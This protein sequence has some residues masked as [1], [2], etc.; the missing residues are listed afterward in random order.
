[1]TEIRQLA[2]YYML[3]LFGGAKSTK[4]WTTLSHNGVV[5]QPPYKQHNIP[6]IYDGKSIM[7]P[8][9]AEEY[10]TLFTRYV[11]TEYYK[12]KVFKKNFFKSWKP[13][14]KGLG[15]DKLELCDFS[16]IIKHLDREKEK[17]ANMSKADKESLK[18][19]TDKNEEKYK[20][21]IV[22]GKEQPVGNFRLEPAGIFIG[23]GC[24]PKLGTIKKRVNSKDITINIGK[25]N[26][27]P[28]PNGEKYGKI[29]HN[30]KAEWLASWPDV[31]SGKTKYVWLGQ[32]SEFKAQSDQDKFDKARKLGKHIEKIRKENT[33]NIINGTLTVKQLSTALYFIDNLALRVGNE[34]GSDQAD[35]VGVT[36]LR[37]EHIMLKGNNIIKLDFLGKDSI[38]YVNQVTVSEKVYEN[39]EKF[40]KDKVN[41]DDLF[42][43]LNSSELNLY[44]K[45]L[46]PD[47][48]AK[49]FRTYNA[50]YTFQQEI[51]N[52]NEKYKSYTK[53]DKMDMLLSSFNT[54]N[55]KVALLCN[56]QKAV[57][58][59]HDEG[60]KKLKDKMLSF[61]KDIEDLISNGN[62]KSK[63][64]IKKLK[65]QVKKYK[66]KKESK[67]ELKNISLGTSKTNYIDPRISVA[68]LKTHDIPVEKIF[69]QTLRDKFF[70]A[71]EVNG[72]YHF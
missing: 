41:G 38:R 69:S 19:A 9:L 13:S 63:K 47:F 2:S 57:S 50:S 3:N 59:S 45:S 54:A 43:L 23:R 24:H 8:P 14:I 6:I 29:V 11:D 25:G 55:A 40:M 15:I 60:M 42:D 48:T 20:V 58:K 17:K 64:K 51:D 66:M 12:N 21:A 18:L 22:D 36:S 61:K 65:D 34:K 28:L 72:D 4:K 53:N 37:Y 68:F 62:D 33:N 44:I 30:N 32:Q 7:L 39:L 31:I 70:W 67:I 26:T 10:I 35:T 71:F 16:Q 1:M 49:V 46:M 56:H 5:F 27:L 52:I